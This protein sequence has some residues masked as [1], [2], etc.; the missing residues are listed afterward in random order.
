LPALS[1]GGA[2]SRAGR[3]L[4][5]PCRLPLRDEICTVVVVRET[6]ARLSYGL[7]A[8]IPA[9]AVKAFFLVEWERVMRKNGG[10][11][12]MEAE[13]SLCSRRNLLLGGT[14]FAAVSAF[15]SAL[16]LEAA[17][18]QTTSAQAG[19]SFA[20]YG[21]SRPMMFLPSKEGDP[22]L[23]SCSSRCSDW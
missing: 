23:N 16:P 15:A 2:P 11:D 10:A 18:A 17:R 12:R 1:A 21:D 19:F 20:V 22:E 14:T 5:Q 9:L 6:L 4:D 3:H 13:G 7:V 8:T